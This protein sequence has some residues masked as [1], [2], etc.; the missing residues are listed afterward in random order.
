MAADELFNKPVFK[1]G[2]ATHN[3]GDLRLLK[4][5]DGS[6]KVSF[7]A[8]AVSEN[9]MSHIEFSTSSILGNRA[10][11]YGNTK[12]MVTLELLSIPTG[13]IAF[14]FHYDDDNVK[15]QTNAKEFVKTLTPFLPGKAAVSVCDS[16]KMAKK[17]SA[18]IPPRQ[19][20]TSVATGKAKCTKCNDGIPKGAIRFGKGRTSQDVITRLHSFDAGSY[21]GKCIKELVE[22]ARDL[23]DCQAN[24]RRIY[25]DK[26]LDKG[27]LELIEKLECAN[28]LGEDFPNLL[29]QVAQYRCKPDDSRPAAAALA[30]SVHRG[31]RGANRR[32]TMPAAKRP[33]VVCN[34]KLEDLAEVLRVK[35]DMKINDLVAEFYSRLPTDAQKEAFIDMVKKTALITLL[36]A[37]AR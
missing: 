28:T 6:A 27:A 25:P 16:S 11:F 13:K 15:S 19:L 34:V 35:G 7:K 3:S 12:S 31:D 1:I 9:L 36:R 23:K 32:E 30:P 14:D 22:R 17:P 24:R 26:T 21:C 4:Y 5:P 18:N 20:L 10:T 37:G 29:Q 2:L 33:R 8:H